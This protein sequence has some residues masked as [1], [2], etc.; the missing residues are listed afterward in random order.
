MEDGNGCQ[1]MLQNLEVEQCVVFDCDVVRSVISP[2][3]DN[4]NDTFEVGCLV[5]N[6]NQ[7][8]VLTVFDR[9]GN[10]VF[11]GQNYDN[12]WRGTD[13]DGTELDEGGY[14]WLLVVGGPGAREVFRGTVTILR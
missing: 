9:W 3:G 2:N 13:L 12:S 7:P 8:N 10:M 5:G 11:E 4:V 14:M 6:A 1:V